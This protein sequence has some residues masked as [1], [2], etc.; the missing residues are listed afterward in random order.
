MSESTIQLDIPLLLPELE[1]SRDACLVQLEKALQYRKGI[2]R[3]HIRPEEEPAQLCLHYD[4]NLISLAAV[5][6]LARQAGSEFT[7]RY[8]HERFP[9]YGMDAADAADA[10]ARILQELP[11]MLHASVNY[12]ADLAAFFAARAQARLH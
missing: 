5:R 4:P 12:A 7:E 9:V 11:G 2:Q 8:R 3:V 10:L 1:D 6:R